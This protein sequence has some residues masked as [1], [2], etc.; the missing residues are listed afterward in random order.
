MGNNSA[1]VMSETL[2]GSHKIWLKFSIKAVHIQDKYDK[3][4]EKQITIFEGKA[5]KDK[6]MCR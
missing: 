4:K 5:N 2:L 1:L 6:N 3:N